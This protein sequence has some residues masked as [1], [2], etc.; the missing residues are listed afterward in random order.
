MGFF[1]LVYRKERIFLFDYSYA[2]DGSNV[3]SFSAILFAHFSAISSNIYRKLVV[4]AIG[5]WISTNTNTWIFFCFVWFYFIFDFISFLQ[6][7]FKFKKNNQFF[8]FFLLNLNNYFDDYR[9]LQVN[10]WNGDGHYFWMEYNFF[11]SF[12][13]F[14]LDVET[15]V[16][17]VA[18][19]C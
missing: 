1:A 3:C 12:F 17:F 7:H 9:I 18:I 15:V 2:N 14:D 11:L 10:Q 6:F 4:P 8:H 13:F 5:W 16:Y 19:K